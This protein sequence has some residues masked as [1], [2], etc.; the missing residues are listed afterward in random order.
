M[1]RIGS[2][3]RASLRI[4]RRDVVRAK[5][6][7]TLVAVMVGTPVLLAVMLTTLVATGDVSAEENLPV[8]LGQA[9]ARV[10]WGGGGAVLQSPDGESGMTTD[11]MRGGVPGTG[12]PP[13][14]DEIAAVVPGSRLVPVRTGWIALQGRPDAVDVLE[15]DLDDPAT[16]GLATVT[17]GRLPESGDEIVVSLGLARDLDA[18]VGDTVQLGGAS[19]EVVGI[20]SYETVAPTPRRRSVVA[21]PAA[22]LLDADDG[23]PDYLVMRDDPVSWDDVKELNALGFWV[24]SRDV[25][26]NPPPTS[27]Q[28][29]EFTSWEGD[30][31][32][33]T[34]LVIVVTAV[35]LQVVLLA[36]PAFAVGVRRQRRD[37]ALLA[38][39][40]GAP[41]DVR[42][43]VL[44]QAIV[45][46]F[47][48][49]LLAAGLG[50][51][52][53]PVV[54]ELLPRWFD[55]IGFGPFEIIWQPV[56]AAVALGTASAVLAAL[57]PARQV[58]KQDVAA[59]LAGR[60]GVVRT[61]N[62]WPVVGVL[63]I[64]AGLG[65]CFTAGTQ[66]GGEN[67][68]A[69][70]TIGVVLGAVFLTPLL[71]GLV[72]RIGGMLPLPLRLAVRDTARQRARSA[73]A[74]AA[75]MATVAG[76]TALAI[77][78]SSDFEQS[79]RL[80]E[81]LTPP[82]VTTLSAPQAV[83]ESAAAASE[84]SGVDFVPIGEGGSTVQD[85]YAYV[86][87]ESGDEDM[88]SGYREIAVATPETLAAWGVELTPDQAAALREG[89]ALVGND[90]RLTA[91][92]RVT[93]GV[94]PESLDGSVEGT[95]AELDAVVA[96]LGLGEVPQGRE[97]EVARAVISPEAA[98]AHGIP[99]STTTA[100]ADRSAG[101]L[102]AEQ[103]AA[104][105]AAAKDVE[106]DASLRTERGFQETFT[107]QLLLLVG[108]GG[109]AVLFGTLTATGLA[110]ADARADL[111]TL[112][113]VGAAPRTRRVV[114]ASQAAV[115]GVLGAL[116]GVAVGFAPGLAA[117][118]PLTSDRWGSL[119]GA[120]GGPIVDIP[121]GVLAAIVFVVPLV[122]VLAS[123]VFTR[124]KLPL[125]RRLAQ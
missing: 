113:A 53:S 32:T 15:A 37:L 100:I 94:H 59:V 36:G 6:R 122:A 61:R 31:G 8:T 110:L 119:E 77:A 112:A 98:R 43:V 65:V 102:T 34:V 91:D 18:G 97:P 30:D 44:A 62:G 104:A 72:G 116:L 99:V 16:D 75:V 21:L 39:S 78:S 33:R 92:G 83:E 38:A 71:I 84:A 41:A 3:W 69:A 106:V 13:P 107:L 48:A 47:G 115:L 108:A 50:I 20:G 66:P 10:S 22:A 111:A 23:G 54:I 7:S 17:E 28:Y 19:R 42:R 93:I 123:A 82:G 1:S 79:R 90:A 67:A 76:I 95:T 52:L 57:V 85:A 49:C 11:E 5:G 4:A 60:S 101:K 109:L 70:G 35:V 81:Y 29:D 51:A 120:D 25:V 55:D 86:S 2:S 27:Q 58:A 105:K 89:T 45:V 118:W 46:G 87:L 121:W 74:I 9:Q 96:D 56:V 73:P 63:L 24:T 26:E 14:S 103:L 117:T 80:Y 88:W 40:G 68:V 124:G 114:A 12:E 125:T 64:A